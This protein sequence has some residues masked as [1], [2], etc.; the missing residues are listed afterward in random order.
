MAIFFFLLGLVF[1]FATAAVGAF[2]LLYYLETDTIDL[3]S[4]SQL[5][6]IML[7]Q[8]SL[9]AG[10]DWGRMTLGVRNWRDYGEPFI[11][12]PALFTPLGLMIFFWLLALMFK[13]PK[14][15]VEEFESLATG[16]S[17]GMH[18]R[19]GGRRS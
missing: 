15:K 1:F 18:R 16:G 8:D 6:Q 9:L 17:G 7:G 4:V 14:I 2:D 10:I 5:W 19:D 3:V 12:S 11:G 13:K